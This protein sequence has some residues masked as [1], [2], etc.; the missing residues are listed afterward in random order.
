MTYYSELRVPRSAGPRAIYAAYR[1]RALQTHPDKGGSHDAYIKVRQA[2]EVLSDPRQRAEYD[3]ELRSTGEPDGVGASGARRPDSGRP[4]RAETLALTG[5]T[6]WQQAARTIV[7]MLN[8]SE[9]LWASAL[10]SHTAEVLDCCRRQ[11]Q[12]CRESPNLRGQAA[13]ESEERSSEGPAIRGLYQTKR[14]TW[15]V[16]LSIQRVQCAIFNVADIARAHDWH[17]ALVELR[18]KVAEKIQSG[19]GDREAFRDAV[20]EAYEADPELRL[21]LSFRVAI[22]EPIRGTGL[23]AKKVISGPFTLRLESALQLRNR[24]QQLRHMGGS[25]QEIDKEIR[26]AKTYE[27]KQRDLHKARQAAMLQEV[28]S[29][30]DQIRREEMRRKQVPPPLALP[31]PPP[32]PEVEGPQAPQAPAAE[33]KAPPAP[34]EEPETRGDYS[35]P[36]KGFAKFC[37]GM[38]LSKPQ[39]EELLKRVQD[40][41]EVQNAIREAI[42]RHCGNLRGSRQKMLAPAPS[43]RGGTLALPA[44]KKAREEKHRRLRLGVESYALVPAAPPGGHVRRK[45]L[46]EILLEKHEAFHPGLLTICELIRVTSCSRRTYAAS[47]G[48]TKRQFSNFRLADFGRNSARSKRGRALPCGELRMLQECLRT[49][50]FAIHVRHLDLST[51]EM[52]PISKEEF[53]YMLGCLPNLASIVLPSRG[54]AG[55]LQLRTFVNIA[56]A[57]KVSIGASAHA[58]I[59][60]RGAGSRQQ[61]S[62]H[63]AHG[64]H[65]PRGEREPREREPR[66]HREREPRGRKRPCESQAPRPRGRQRVDSQ[67]VSDRPRLVLSTPALPAPPLPAPQ[68]LP[69]PAA[70]PE[71]A[72]LPPAPFVRPELP[73]S[74]PAPSPLRALHALRAAQPAPAPATTRRAQSAPS[75]SALNALRGGLRRRR[76]TETAGGAGGSGA[77][78]GRRG[79]VEGDHGMWWLSRI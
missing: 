51:L 73:Q 40:D 49:R 9:T 79:A 66:D 48:A 74:P 72:P 67:E 53:Q 11:L 33:R 57:L 32:A 34:Q 76:D 15:E 26:D 27:K 17:I 78:G 35:V 24:V 31:A 68:A 47:S 59:I 38:S 14:G 62:V 4:Q 65:A 45:S 29:A 63:G 64:A 37:R 39:R 1:N 23:A 12:R 71:V 19:E 5:D 60:L 7:S 41:T 75:S 10:E 8:L 16:S 18:Q 21:V 30:L 55:T 13:K 52:A 22:R 42:A 2:F 77:N 6:P 44:P 58:D 28:S 3:A 25:P 61:S 20:Q 56:K 46:L 69:A 54:W 43:Q 36:M 50:R 70:A